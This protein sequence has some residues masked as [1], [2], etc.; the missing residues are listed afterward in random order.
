MHR[1]AFRQVG[2]TSRS[3]Q[4]HFR[5]HP[6]VTALSPSASS[7]SE[8]PL[9]VSAAVSVSPTGISGSSNGVWS[10]K[11]EVNVWLSALDVACYSI[12]SN[13]DFVH[14]L[15]ICSIRSFNGL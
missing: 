5:E 10:Q 8:S 7:S 2:R 3:I 6:S 4:P 13:G 9:G 11:N 14:Y 1:L 15:F 12:D